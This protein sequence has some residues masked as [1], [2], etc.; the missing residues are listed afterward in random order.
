M[1]EDLG[2]YKELVEEFFPGIEM[3]DEEVIRI[4]FAYSLGYRHGYSSVEPPPEEP[5]PKR[6]TIKT[7]KGA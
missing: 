7:E 6:R 3:S 4:G 1:S 5:V 2:M